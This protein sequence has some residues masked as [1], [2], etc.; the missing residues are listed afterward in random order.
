[1]PP[2][3]NLDAWNSIADF[4]DENL[5]DEGNDLF[6][7]LLLPTVE[8]LVAVQDGEMVLD[9]GTGNGIV[10]RRLA[11]E[12]ITVIATDYSDGQLKNA[13]ERANRSGKEIEFSQLD[14]TDPEA[15]ESFATVHSERFDVVVASML[16]KELSTLGPLAKFLPKVLKPNGRI[17]MANPHPCFQ[18]PGAHRV[19]EVL[20]NP[21]TGVQE[22]HS[23]IKVRKYLNIGPVKSQALRGQPHPLTWFHRPIHGLLNPFLKEGLL[24]GEIR[25]PSFDDG[26]DPKQIQ[27]YHNFAQIPML[28]IFKLTR[29]P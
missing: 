10:A 8:Q 3:V 25:E 23:S 29:T 26:E 24:V 22:F 14:L 18:K 17:V 11:R 2:P 6:R 7:Q 12:G 21:E 20:E 4:W 13:A 19:V 28:F 27:S 16:L 15:L 5:S 1:M 9:I